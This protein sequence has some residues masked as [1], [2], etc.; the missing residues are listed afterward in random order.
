MILVAR[1]LSRHDLVLLLDDVEA[2]VIG[3]LAERGEQVSCSI[4]VIIWDGISTFSEMFRYADEALYSAKRNGRSCIV[5]EKASDR[6]TDE[7][8]QKP[9]LFSL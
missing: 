2:R 3:I 6:R 5:V 1:K 7:A 4:G 8:E 9:T